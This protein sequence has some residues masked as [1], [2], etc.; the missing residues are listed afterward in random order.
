MSENNSEEHQHT[1]ACGSECSHKEQPK[2]PDPIDLGFPKADPK[3]PAKPMSEKTMNKYVQKALNIS[4]KDVRTMLQDFVSSN[5][6]EL[7]KDVV[8]IAP[9]DKYE[10]LLDDVPSISKFMASEGN[11]SKNWKLRWVKS[12]VQDDTPLVMFSFDNLA[13]DNGTIVKAYVFVDKD[14][15]QLYSTADFSSKFFREENVAPGAKKKSGGVPKSI[16]DDKKTEKGK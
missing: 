4:I 13:A 16:K 7:C 12:I 2:G 15:E 5:I 8:S 1:D 14:G 9:Y 6:E 3:K 11:K 10:N